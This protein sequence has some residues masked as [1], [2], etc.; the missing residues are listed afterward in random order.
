MDK[1]NEVKNDRTI[2]TRKVVESRRKTEKSRVSQVDR[3]LKF[4]KIKE[5]FNEIKVRNVNYKRN[6]GRMIKYL[7]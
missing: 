1:N 4:R 7:I 3:R 2:R 6:K 5:T